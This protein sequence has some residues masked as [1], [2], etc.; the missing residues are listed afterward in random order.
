[1]KLSDFGCATYFGSKESAIRNTF[2]GTLDYLAPEMLIDPERLRYGY[3]VDNWS[4]GI[5]AYELVYGCTPFAH[6]EEQEA[7]V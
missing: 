6:L 2:C 7:V 3:K 4:I 5:L 1:M